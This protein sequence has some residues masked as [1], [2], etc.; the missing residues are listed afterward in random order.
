V[1]VKNTD[2]NCKKYTVNEIKLTNMTIVW[3]E[4]WTTFK[5]SLYVDTMKHIEHLSGS[6]R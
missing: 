1:N 4:K 6:P 5:L 2:R 3:A